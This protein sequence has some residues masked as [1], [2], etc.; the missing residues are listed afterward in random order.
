MSNGGFL[1][2]LIARLRKVQEEKDKVLVQ[3]ENNKDDGRM[4][5]HNDNDYDGCGS[6]CD[7]GGGSSSG[8]N[9]EEVGS[10][11]FFFE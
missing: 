6:G 9:I 1:Q 2:V 10:L 7:S 8:D 11:I 5:N 3:K 4:V